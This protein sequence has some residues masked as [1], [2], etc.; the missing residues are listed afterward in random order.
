MRRRRIRQTNSFDEGLALEVLSMKEEAR[1]LPPGETRGLLLRRTRKA[2]IALY[3]SEW[4]S[5]PKRA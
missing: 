1:A 5:A 2:E 3:V 4:L